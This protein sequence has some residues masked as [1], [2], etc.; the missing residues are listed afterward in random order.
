M[1][2]KYHTKIVQQIIETISKLDDEAYVKK[3][4]VLHDNSL[5]QHFRHVLEFYLCLLE[6]RENGIVNYDQRKRDLYIETDKSYAIIVANNIL[7]NLENLDCSTV[8]SLETCLRNETAIIPSNF[9]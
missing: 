3:L 8:I 2:K 9:I 5:G 4:P 6:A 1:T 7:A